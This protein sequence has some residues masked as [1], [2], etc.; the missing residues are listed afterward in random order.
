MPTRVKC[1]H[2]LVAHALAVGA[3]GEEVVSEINEAV[4][5]WKAAGR[6]DRISVLRALAAI[7][8]VYD[9]EEVIRA[10]KP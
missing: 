4:G 2:V 9:W 3:F 7:E 5:A 6:T 10:K 8:G 1:L